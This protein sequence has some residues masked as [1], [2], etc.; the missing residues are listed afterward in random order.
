MRMK[1]FKFEYKGVECWYSRSIAVLAI[2]TCKDI[3][4]NT[5]VL[6]NKRGD[7]TPDYQGMWNMPCGYLDFNESCE[8]AVIREVLEETGLEIKDRKAIKLYMINDDPN[9]PK[10]LRQNVTIRYRVDYREH[11]IENTN[12][13]TKFSEENEVSNVK[14]IK[15]KNLM[16]YDWAFNHK[17]LLKEL[18]L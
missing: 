17:E 11:I 8:D 1:N 16:D 6:A 3:D 12:L 14:W 15:L 13:H 10:N 9:D 18:F 4:G 2:V 7:G 5:Y